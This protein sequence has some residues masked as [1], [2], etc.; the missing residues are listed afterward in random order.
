MAT[1]IKEWDQV[2]TVLTVRKEHSGA[3]NWLSVPMPV[4]GFNPSSHPHRDAGRELS[5]ALELPVSFTVKGSNENR[6]EIKVGNRVYMKISHGS[7]VDLANRYSHGSM[8]MPAAPPDFFQQYVLEAEIIDFSLKKERVTAV[9]SLN[10]DRGHLY[11][12]CGPL[13]SLYMQCSPA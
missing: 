10:C 4:D 2:A 6:P 12:V 5:L 11:G 3:H 1:D 9:V 7:C 13:L 8:S